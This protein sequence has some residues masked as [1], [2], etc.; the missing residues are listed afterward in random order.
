M[1]A[2]NTARWKVID[3]QDIGS[4]IFARKKDLA[5]KSIDRIAVG[6]FRYGFDGSAIKFKGT[7]TANSLDEP[8]GTVQAC[9]LHYGLAIPEKVSVILPQQRGSPTQL[10]VKSVDEP[11][12]T[13]ASAGADALATAEFFAPFH[14][15]CRPKAGMTPA[16]I[17]PCLVAISHGNSKKESN[18]NW[19]RARSVDAPL[20]TVTGSNDLGVVTCTASQGTGGDEKPVIIKTWQDLSAAIKA[21]IKRAKKEPGYRPLISF[22]RFVIRLEVKFRMLKWRELARAQSFPEDYQFGG[23]DT[24]RVKMIG[25]AVPPALARAVVKAAVSQCPDVGIWDGEGDIYRKAS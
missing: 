12:P 11:L 21:G 24:D 7:G 17:N 10:R 19:R 14:G 16:G 6:I 18:P 1:A 3:W 2:W 22:R 9:G 13:I 20:D 23:T 25:N 5:D 8:L 4:S 15:E